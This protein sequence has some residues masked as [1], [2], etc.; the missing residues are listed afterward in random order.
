MSKRDEI[1]DAAVKEFGE[2]S[3]DAASINRIIKASG[4]SKGTFYHYFKDKKSLYLTIIENSMKIK[5]ELMSRM[6]TDLKQENK[7]FFDMIKSQSKV[8]AVFV[9]KNPELYK[10]A[11]MYASEQG[12]IKKEVEKMIMP[13]I[14][15]TFVK[16]I[17]AGIA[18]KN[19]TDR[20][21]PEFIAKI[22]SHLT[23]NYYDILFEKNEIPSM[24]EAEKRLDMLF[25][26][27]KRGFT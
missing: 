10:F 12:P 20:Y 7:D 16:M 27:L 1:I 26:F 13:E 18:N 8:A 2:F 25:D 14:G 21:P 15:D 5:K 9:E 17:E 6:M 24:E 22:I 23:V 19:F 11:V 4:T 3:Y